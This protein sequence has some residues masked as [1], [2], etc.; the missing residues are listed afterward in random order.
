MANAEST[1]ATKA[2]ALVTVALQNSS[3]RLLPL[4]STSHSTAVGKANAECVAK[5]LVDLTAAIKDLE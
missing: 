3:L 1:A 5:M 4:N 2:L